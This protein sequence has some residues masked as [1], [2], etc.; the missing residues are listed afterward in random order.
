[1]RQDIGKTVALTHCGKTGRGNSHAILQHGPDP[2]VYETPGDVVAIQGRN[3]AD[4]DD[5]YGAHACE[6]KSQPWSVQGSVKEEK[7]GQHTTNPIGKRP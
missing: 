3:L 4:A 6:R 7:T 5:G 1:M 2:H